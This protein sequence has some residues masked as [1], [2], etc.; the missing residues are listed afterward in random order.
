MRLK[1]P[2]PE[3]PEDGF[4]GIDIFGREKTADF[5]LNLATG[6]E[7]NMTL[8]LDAPWGSGKSFFLKQFKKKA[9]Q[10]GFPCI[11]FDAFKNDITDSAFAAISGEIVSEL[12]ETEGIS[13]QVKAGFKNAAAGAGKLLLKGALNAGVSF[14]TAGL[15]SADNIQKLMDGA[16]GK[17]AAEAVA[18]GLSAMLNS[19]SES[20]MSGLVEAHA[21]SQK[22]ISDLRD[23]VKIASEKMVEELAEEGEEKNPLKRAFFIIDELDRCRPDFAIDVLE[24]V[25]HFYDVENIVFIYSADFEKLNGAI[26][27]RYGEGVDPQR[28]I[29]KFIDFWI[30][31]PSKES[32][33]DRITSKIYLDFLLSELPPHEFIRNLKELLDDCVEHTPTSLREIQKIFQYFMLVENNTTDRHLRPAAAV[34]TLSFF[35]VLAPPV[36]FKLANGQINYLTLKSEFQRLGVNLENE[37]FSWMDSLLRY[38]LSEDLENENDNVKEWRK[39]FLGYNVNNRQLMEIIANRFMDQFELPA[40]P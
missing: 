37:Q 3:I 7:D 12:N 6:V 28:Y 4:S 34:V 16:G 36:Y 13:G 19:A 8:A 15:C 23:A 17:N 22:T 14:A 24:V 26:K 2:E 39:A 9:E 5:I 25:K 10:Q 21:E 33:R 29:E 27:Q 40:Q 18:K 38:C 32:R 20:A 35:R 11:V 30:Q 1:F 31:F